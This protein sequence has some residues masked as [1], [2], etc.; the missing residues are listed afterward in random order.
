MDAAAMWLRTF[1]IDATDIAGSTG[2]PLI[3]VRFT[4]PA[5]SEV[6][7]GIAAQEAARRLRDAVKSVAFAGRH[8]L[9]RRRDGRWV[10][11]G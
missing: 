7:E 5:S 2:A 3:L 9:L 1:H 4:V 6:E 8:R 10:P 11:V